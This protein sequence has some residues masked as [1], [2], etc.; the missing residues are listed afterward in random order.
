MPVVVV[1]YDNILVVAALFGYLLVS[2]VDYRVFLCLTAAVDFAELGGDPVGFGLT[3]VRNSSSAT[4]AFDMR[5][6]ALM[7]G[8]NVKPTIDEV[9]LRLTERVPSRFSFITP[10]A[11]ISARSPRFFVS[12]SSFKP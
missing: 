12:S 6:A 1:D 7:R 9:I 2:L 3:L 11:C 8:A 10:D 4:V 5:P